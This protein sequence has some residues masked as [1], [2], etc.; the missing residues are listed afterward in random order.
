VF[1]WLRPDVDVVGDVSVADWI[2]ST[3]E[4]WSHEGA[5]LASFMPARFERHARVLHP[6]EDWN[7]QSP[8]RLWRDVGAE[9][10]IE[11]GPETTAPELSGA[12]EPEGGD[13]PDQGRLP[14]SICVALAGLLAAKTAT[15]DVCWFGMWF[16]WGVLTGPHDE[17]EAN[18]GALPKVQE[19]HGPT[20]RRYFLLRGP[21]DAACSFE[22]MR[23]SV[24]DRA[25]VDEDQH[26]PWLSVPGRAMEDD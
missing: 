26:H 18:L 20:G 22:P 5:R 1:E 11:V 13:L 4:P 9:R 14:G 24:F 2:V 3:L 10:G 19:P 23:G 12:P 8:P 7:G 17:D 15:P 25:A 21:V 16:G 6:F